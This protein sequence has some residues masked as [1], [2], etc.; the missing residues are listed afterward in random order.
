MNRGTDAGMATE[1]DADADTY[2][3]ADAEMVAEMNAK[4]EAAV[5]CGQSHEGESGCGFMGGFEMNSPKESLDMQKDLKAALAADG[6][7]GLD[8]DPQ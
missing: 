2:S 8:G 5:R 4:G 7:G 1:T 6:E 3:G